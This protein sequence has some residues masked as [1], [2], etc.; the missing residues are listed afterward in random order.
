MHDGVEVGFMYASSKIIN[1]VLKVHDAFAICA[2][3]IS[4]YA[5]L[6]ALR[7]TNGKDGEGDKF[8]KNLVH[9]LDERRS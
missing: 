9:V 8:I 3:T 1:Q 2:P 4:Q 6:A 7:A 5:A